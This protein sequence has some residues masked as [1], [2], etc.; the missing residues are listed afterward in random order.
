M[1]LALER[2]V[3]LSAVQNVMG[4]VARKASLPI[5]QNLHIKGD[6]EHITV[7]ATDLETTLIS[8][9]ANHDL[10]FE[11]TLPAKRLYDVLRAFPDGSTVGIED[12]DGKATV[13]CGRSRFSLATLDP[14]EFPILPTTEYAHQFF[15]P[16]NLLKSLLDYVDYATAENDVR[17]YLNGVMMEFDSQG[18]F[19]VVATDGHRLAKV[20][21]AHSTNYQGEVTKQVIVPRVGMIELKRLLKGEEDCEVCFADNH[22]RVNLPTSTFITKLIEGKFPDYNRVIPRER[23]SQAVFHREELLNAIGRIALI[24]D[25]KTSGIELNFSDGLFTARSCNSSQEE[26][27]EQIDIEYVGSLVFGMN[28]S[29]LMD[30]LRA[31][32]SEKV[33]FKM[34]TAGDSLLIEGV[35][36]DQ[37]T[38]VL[39]P[40][41]L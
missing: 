24:K 29:Y 40:M 34:N 6:G 1:K 33:I 20:S 37:A 21:S 16:M 26:G 27:E 41:R 30:T 31:I 15:I 17:Y 18:H 4:A 23:K 14:L 8:R 22:I 12:K 39:M 25:D 9:F 32:Q 36:T 35:E 28:A 10:P 38:H 13:K 11:A 3:L 2:N 19:N 5:L 7:T